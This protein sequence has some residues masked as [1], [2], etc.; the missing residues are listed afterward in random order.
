MSNIKIFKVYSGVF[1]RLKKFF[2]K[3]DGTLIN[4]LLLCFMPLILFIVVFYLKDEFSKFMSI[5]SI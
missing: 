3:T 4:F 5:A 1:M 2:A